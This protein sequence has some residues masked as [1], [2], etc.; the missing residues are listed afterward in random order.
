MAPKKAKKTKEELEAERL[1]E[2]AERAKQDA[3]EK[4]KQAELEEKRRQEEIRVAAERKALRAAELARLG[5]EY[6]AYEDALKES[7]AQQIA[8]DALE[9][10]ERDPL[11]KLNL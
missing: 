2:E 9:V 6:S 5:E 11:I 1:A 3:I 7:R 4:K 10:R 8:D